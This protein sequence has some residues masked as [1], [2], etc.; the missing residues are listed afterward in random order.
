MK[1]WE[2]KD[3]KTENNAERLSWAGRSRERAQGRPSRPTRAADQGG[4]MTISPPANVELPTKQKIQTLAYGVDSLVVAID[5]NW[6]RSNLFSYL[7]KLKN[8]AKAGEGECAGVL[9]TEDNSDEWPFNIKAHGVRGYDWLLDGREFVLR[10]GNWKTP[11]SRPSVMAEIH[12]ETLWRRGPTDSVNRIVSLLENNGASLISV[13]V[14]RVDVCVDITIPKDMW[15]L[16]LLNY[17][18]KRAS[19]ISSH[20]HHHDLTGISIGRGKVSARIYDKFL[21]IKQKSKKFWMFD[22]WDIDQVPK[23]KK[24]IRIEFQLRR[25]ALKQM[26]LDTFD[27]FFENIENVWAYC[28][29]KWLKFEDNPG[30]HH[31]Q[32]STLKWWEM[33]QNGFNGVQNPKPIVRSRAFRTDMKQLASQAFGQITSL[34]AARL[35]EQGAELNKNVNMFETVETYLKVLNEDGKDEKAL[36]KRIALKRARYHRGKKIEEQ[37][38]EP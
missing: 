31:T 9:K 24:I 26:G 3:T 36:N 10:I 14:S 5:I 33:V 13:R 11:K 23:G 18:V 21:E 12:C 8:L 19:D 30:M 7:E 28:T 6:T 20:Y 17:A 1:P 22:V 15:S 2:Q 37:G 27:D 16:D 34:E 4:E 35:E 32:R 25:E 29:K 38:T